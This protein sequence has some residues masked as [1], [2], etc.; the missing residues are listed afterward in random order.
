MLGLAAHLEISVGDYIGAILQFYLQ[1]RAKRRAS[2]QAKGIRVRSKDQTNIGFAKKFISPWSMF[3]LICSCI[4]IPLVVALAG[5]VAMLVWGRTNVQQR[6]D[7]AL[8]TRDE[9]LEKLASKDAVVASSIME[10]SQHLRM[11]SPQREGVELL[12]GAWAK[13]ACTSSGQPREDCLTEAVEVEDLKCPICLETVQDCVALLPCGHNLCKS[14]SEAHLMRLR[15][16][17]CPYTCAVDRVVPN[18]QARAAVA[19]LRQS[20]DSSVDEKPLDV[21]MPTQGVAAVTLCRRPASMC[22]PIR[23]S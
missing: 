9:S 12:P 16:P 15:S 13:A 11:H 23:D 10:E 3:Y 18:F 17:R 4:A 5:F 7:A 21:Q 6:L 2:G 19:K 8:H 20:T 14:C 1:R 22:A